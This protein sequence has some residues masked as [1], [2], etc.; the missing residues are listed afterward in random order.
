VCVAA[1]AAFVA[2]IAAGIAGAERRAMWESAC[3]A[4]AGREGDEA[5][6]ARLEAAAAGALPDSFVTQQ[7]WVLTALQNA[8]QRLLHAPDAETAL[9]ETVGQGG[10]TDTNAAIAGALMGAAFGRGAFP[11]RWV[12]KVLA[13]RPLAALGANQPR[14]EEYWPDDVPALA[15]AVREAGQARTRTGSWTPAG[16]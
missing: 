13:C 15:E 6:R 9:I 8:F 1:S 4:T 12:L 2:A 14:P 11:A 7:G 3:W 10:D 5:V 16:S